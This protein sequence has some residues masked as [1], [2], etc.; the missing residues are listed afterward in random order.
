[1]FQKQLNKVHKLNKGLVHTQTG[2][3][4]YASPEVWKD[5]PYNTKSDIWSLGCMYNNL[6]QV[7]MNQLL[8]NHLLEQTICLNNYL[9]NILRN[10]LFKKVTSGIYDPLPKNYSLDLTN[11]IQQLL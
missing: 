9:C 11:M 1:M 5:K 7:C 2:T 10:G 3:P 4:Y 6:K 8:F